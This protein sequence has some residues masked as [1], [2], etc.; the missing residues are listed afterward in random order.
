MIPTAFSP[1]TDGVNDFY[2]VRTAGVTDFY[3]AVFNRWGEQVFETNDTDFEWDGNY[4]GKRMPKGVYP[5]YIKY[6]GKKTIRQQ[7]Q[8]TIQIVR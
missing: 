4:M 3:M 6:K 7:T 5:Y 8:G 2:H 1:G